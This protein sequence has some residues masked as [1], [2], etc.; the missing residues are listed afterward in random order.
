MARTG[1]KSARLRTA[2]V[3]CYLALGSIH[4]V[5][6]FVLAWF[7]KSDAG[8]FLLSGIL[9]AV[10]ASVVATTRTL[11]VRDLTIFRKIGTGNK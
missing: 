2:L 3:C 11:S 7:S 4:S 10:W 8:A 5:A 1:S 6:A 9:T